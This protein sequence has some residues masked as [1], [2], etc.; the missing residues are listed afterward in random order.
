LRRRLRPRHALERNLDSQV[1]HGKEIRDLEMIPYPQG[2]CR[3]AERHS[4]EKNARQ[5]MAADR[6]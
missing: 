4:A 1:F 6:A 3:S 5:P 2:R